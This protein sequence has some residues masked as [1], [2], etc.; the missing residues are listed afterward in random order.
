LVVF[1][2]P[3]ADQALPFQVLRELVALKGYAPAASF[4]RFSPDDHD[5]LVRRLEDVER[6]LGFYCS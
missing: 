1:E 6:M 4:H 5:G 3:D 2:N